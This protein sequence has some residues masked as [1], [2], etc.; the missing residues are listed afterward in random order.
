MTKAAKTLFY[1]G[2]YMIAIG[3]ILLIVP[4]L[5]LRLAGL[6]P[7]NEVWIR[8]MGMLVLILAYYY[9]RAARNELT[10]FFRWTVPARSSAILFLSAFVAFGLIK[11]I[12]ILFGVIDLAGAIWTALTLRSSIRRKHE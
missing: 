12:A 4:N 6:P 5:L 8:V 3:I 10:I 1:F 2:I 7:T 11:P 9:I